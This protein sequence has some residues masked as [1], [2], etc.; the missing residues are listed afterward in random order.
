MRRRVLLANAGVSV[1]G[2]PVDKLGE[3]IALPGP[4]PVELPSR[5]DWV[6]VSQVR[7]QTRRLGKA[8]NATFADPVVLS[9][10]AARAERLLGVS[11][12]G[13]VKRAL[14]VAVAELHIAAGWA[15]FD[16]WRYDRAMHHF[17]AALRL[18]TRAGDA[19]LQATALGGAGL[20]TVEH[21]HPND[22]LKFLQF[23]VVKAW[24]IPRDEQRAVMVD[25]SGRVAR[26]ACAR[27][28]AATAMADLGKLNDAEREIAKSRELWS[29]TRTDPFGDLDRPAALVALRR[30][31]LDLAEQFAAASV[32][33]W[34]GIGQ[35]GPIKSG[36]VLATIHVRA[37]EPRGLPLAHG[38]IT[39]VSKL[40]SIWIRQ[41][42]EPL[43]AALEA[44]PGTD[45]KDLARMARQV[46]SA[47]V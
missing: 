12:A 21:G 17:T 18:A 42:L 16:A 15:G 41:R 11:G 39:A 31:R 9:T 1:V 37:G 28:T 10:A 5:I 44:R 6:H 40:S 27:A 46:S 38:A 7:D 29:P 36:I 4:A 33:R 14:M 22:G 43:I 20:A 34:K 19:Y 30:G 24:D 23:S 26:E 45:T 47:R 25:V 3:L 8:G 13:P 35:L 2:R 32:L